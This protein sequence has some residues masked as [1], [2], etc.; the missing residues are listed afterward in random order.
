MAYM[1]KLVL[2][3][4]V[5]REMVGEGIQLDVVVMISLFF[6]CSQLGWLR[7][8]KNVHRWNIGRRLWLGLYLGRDVVLWAALILGCGM[9]GSVN[10]ALDL[11]Y[12]MCR[13]GL[14]PTEITFVGILYACRYGGSVD[15]GF[16]YFKKMREVYGIMPKIEHYGGIV[17]LLT[18]AG[19]VQEAHD[20]IQN[21]P[22]DPNCM[23]IRYVLALHRIMDAERSQDPKEQAANEMAS[24][25]R[26]PNISTSF[27]LKFQQLSQPPLVCDN[28]GLNELLQPFDPGGYHNPMNATTQLPIM[29]RFVFDPG[30]NVQALP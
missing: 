18:R 30:I 10:V 25:I 15:Q 3:L 7:H 29:I 19:W 9:N 6:I 16:E 11:F 4:M 26:D 8:G 14:V 21:V 2:G 27:H 24:L 20:F 12:L 13:E 23:F 5:F 17:D 28:V 22:L 1:G